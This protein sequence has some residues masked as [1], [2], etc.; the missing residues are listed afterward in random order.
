MSCA[1]NPQ[2]YWQQT[3]LFLGSSWSLST[4][5]A[6]NWVLCFHSNSEAMGLALTREGG[7]LTTGSYTAQALYY[8]NISAGPH[9]TFYLFM[10]TSHDCLPLSHCRRVS[11]NFLRH[12]CSLFSSPQCSSVSTLTWQQTSTSRRQLLKPEHPA[13]IDLVFYLCCDLRH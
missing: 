9:Q 13:V 6:P 7:A 10:T 12:N 3:S 8:L 5:P 1:Q 11:Q 2:P 4:L